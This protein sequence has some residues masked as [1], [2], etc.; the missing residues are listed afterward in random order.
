MQEVKQ[1][2][3][4]FQHNENF[5][6]FTYEVG[7][8]Y[9]IQDIPSGFIDKWIRCGH[10]IVENDKDLEVLDDARSKE[11]IESEYNAMIQNEE[12]KRK[13]FE[14]EHSAK[15]EVKIVEEKVVEPPKETIELVEEKE[16]EVEENVEEIEKEQ[17]NKTSRRRKNKNKQ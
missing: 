14:L 10:V 7:K 9:L 1:K 17:S 5:R 13:G 4:L 15:K 3:I 11:H 12:K 8:A 16:I 2:V 6:G